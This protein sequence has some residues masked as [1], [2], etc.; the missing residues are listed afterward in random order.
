[1][2]LAELTITFQR[3]TPLPGENM[4]TTVIVFL[5][6][7]FLGCTP[8]H[9]QRAESESPTDIKKTVITDQTGRSWDISHAFSA[10]K[11]KP[12]YFNFGIGVGAIPSVDV[13]IVIDKD[14]PSF[15]LPDEDFAIFGVDHN[16]QQRAYS[17]SALTRHE[18]YND[19][20]PGDVDRY[21]SVAY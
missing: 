9:E 20:Y 6:A 12:K 15:P 17:V 2:Y 19:V 7:S 8:S 16:G 4:R 18:V 3:G 1:M 14:D 10:Y 11:M 21:V 5:L 13:P